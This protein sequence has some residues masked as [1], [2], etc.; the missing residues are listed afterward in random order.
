MIKSR[1]RLRHFGIGLCVV[2]QSRHHERD[3]LQSR[4][5]QTEAAIALLVLLH[6]VLLGEDALESVRM[7][8]NALRALCAALEGLGAVSEKWLPNTKRQTPNSKRKLHKQEF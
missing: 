2:L 5:Q 4:I 8:Q 6:V 7:P 3:T 1:Q